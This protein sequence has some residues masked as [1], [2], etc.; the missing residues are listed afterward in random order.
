MQCAPSRHRVSQ[1]TPVDEM[2]RSVSRVYVCLF[3][4]GSLMN[5]TSSPQHLKTSLQVF[6][7]PHN[8]N[9]DLSLLATAQY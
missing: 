9:P 1:A 7:D 4:L 2:P 5:L 8:N 6:S 3:S